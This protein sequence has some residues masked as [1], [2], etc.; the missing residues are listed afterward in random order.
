MTVS[1]RIS[2]II[3]YVQ[4]AIKE[5][6]FEALAKRISN[7]PPDS[8]QEYAAL[9]EEAQTLVN[10][11][12]GQRELPEFDPAAAKAARAQALQGY[13]A[14]DADLDTLPAPPPPPPPPGPT[15]FPYGKEQNQPP[16]VMD[17]A[18]LL[19]SGDVIYRRVDRSALWIV[20]AAGTPN[21][22]DPAVWTQDQIVP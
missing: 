9:I 7:D 2:G 1:N 20:L 10:E 14:S 16:R 8:I 19:R 11:L 15:V 17:I 22:L 6:K 3:D 21:T 4:R 18:H 12:L 5:R 13:M